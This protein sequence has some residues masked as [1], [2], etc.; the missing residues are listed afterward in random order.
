LERFGDGGTIDL[1][2]SDIVMPNGMNGIDLAQEANVRYPGLSVLLTTGCSDVT[3]S[4]ET[5]FPILHKPFEAAT[6]ERAVS[7]VLRGGG[8]VAGQSDSA[9]R[10]RVTMC[11]ISGAPRA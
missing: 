10:S 7:E 2:L 11:A 3:A 9:A 4:A 5:R 8:G 1:L 6:L